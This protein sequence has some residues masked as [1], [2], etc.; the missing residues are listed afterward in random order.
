[1]IKGSW[2]VGLLVVLLGSA[3]VL[4]T[5]DRCRGD[6]GFLVIPVVAMKFKGNWYATQTYNAN[7]VV[8][9]NGSSWFSIT[10]NKGQVPDISPNQWTMLVKKGDTGATRGHRTS[11]TYTGATG[12]IGPIGPTGD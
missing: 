1:M 9:Y 3:A 7:D 2:V 12:P 6:D 11:G 5:V 8:F 10:R 4:G